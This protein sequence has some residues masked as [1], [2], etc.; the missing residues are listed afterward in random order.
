MFNIFL[1]QCRSIKHI[2]TIWSLQKSFKNLFHIFSFLSSFSPPCLTIFLC[3]HFFNWKFI[4]HILSLF[5]FPLSSIYLIIMCREREIESE[6][7][8]ESVSERE[9]ESE[10]ESE[11]E[12]ERERERERESE[13]NTDKYSG[14]LKSGRP[15]SGKHQNM[16]T[17]LHNPNDQNRDA[18]L[19]LSSANCTNHVPIAQHLHV[20][21]L[22]Q[23]TLQWINN[24]F[25]LNKTRPVWTGF[26]IA[27][28]RK[29]LTHYYKV[30]CLDAIIICNN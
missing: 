10:S 16:D 2:F 13:W 5:F 12:R 3:V 28:R 18:I 11:W 29:L 1:L 24:K 8:R 21:S 6:R 19:I 27:V 26:K 9:R 30:R 14:C 22:N 20:C 23:H 7:E 25:F 15:K 17:I 4:L